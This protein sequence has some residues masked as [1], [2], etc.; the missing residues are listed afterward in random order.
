[1]MDLKQLA[2]GIAADVVVK[3]LVHVVDALLYS[4]AGRHKYSYL[5][6]YQDST[7]ADTEKRMV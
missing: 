5:A 4:K 7:C 3:I 1:M 6:S 2:G